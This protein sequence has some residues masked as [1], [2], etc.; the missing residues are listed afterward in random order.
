MGYLDGLDET[1]SVA[2]TR[3]LDGLDEDTPIDARNDRP[4][5]DGQI[6]NALDANTLLR[7]IQGAPKPTVEPVSKD[8]NRFRALSPEAVPEMVDP[9]T[10]EIDT[11]PPGLYQGNEQ[12]FA[13]LSGA[14]R[15][16]IQSF[17]TE[18]S[19]GAPKYMPGYKEERP[20]GWEK[21]PVGIGGAAGFIYGGPVA[22]FKGVTKGIVKKLP[23]L[24]LLGHEGGI[25]RFLKTAAK[26]VPA[27]SAAS[28]V[29]SAV[30]A[31]QAETP[32]QAWGILKDAA[33]G[34]ALMGGTFAGARSA[35]WRESKDRLKRMAYGMLAMRTIRGDPT[36]W[37]GI[38]EE[39]THGIIDGFFLL[40]G[41]PD[42]F[43]RLEKDARAKIKE[44]GIDEKELTEDVEKSIETGETFNPYKKMSLKAVQ[45][46]ARIGVDLAKVELARRES[47]VGEK[48]EGDVPEFESID[49]EKTF[50]SKKGSVYDK[51]DGVWYSK[52]G[53]KVT[54]TYIIKAAEKGSKGVVKEGEEIVG[55]HGTGLELTDVQERTSFSPDAKVSTA[56]AKERGDLEGNEPRLYKGKIKFENPKT[57]K[58]ED[59]VGFDWY[60]KAKEEGHDGVIITDGGKPVEYVVIKPE[61]VK[62]FNLE[63]TKETEEKAE[64][65]KVTAT[66][67]SSTRTAARLR[68]K[69]QTEQGIETE[70]VE[71]DGRFFLEPVKTEPELPA[72]TLTELRRRIASR[73]KEVLSGKGSEEELVELEVEME[74]LVSTRG[75]EDFK[76][77]SAYDEF[78]DLNDTVLDM[79][80]Q[81]K[82]EE[83]MPD[84]SIKVKGKEEETDYEKI[85]EKEGMPEE[86][87]FE[88][89]YKGTTFDFVGAQQFY[90]ILVGKL[91]KLTE[92]KGSPKEITKIKG[93]IRLVRLGLDRIHPAIYP[94][95]VIN[96]MYNITDNLGIQEVLDI[97]G[98]TGRIGKIKN[99]GFK[100]KIIANELEASWKGQSTEQIQKDFGVDSTIIGDARK[101]DIP[102]DSIE[103]IFTSPTYGNR[104]GLTGKNTYTD[105]VGKELDKGNTGGII[106]GPEYEGIHKDAY[107][108]SFRVLKPGGVF[109]LNMKDWPTS[110]IK[111]KKGSI[112]NVEDCIV[113]ATDWHISALEE[114]GFNTIR[115]YRVEEGRTVSSEH[116]LARKSTVGYEDIVIVQKPGGNYISKEILDKIDQEPL[117]EK[118]G[119][120]QKYNYY[121]EGEIT[122]DFLGLQQIWEGVKGRGDR[123]GQKELTRRAIKKREGKIQL[124]TDVDLSDI[125]QMARAKGLTDRESKQLITSKL[126]WKRSIKDLTREEADIIK[127]KLAQREAREVMEN[128][129]KILDN[130][131][132]KDS[133]KKVLKR[134]TRTYD[135]D[136]NEL[137]DYLS[138]WTNESG[139]F[140]NHDV[141]RVIATIRAVNELRPEKGRV[142]WSLLAPAKRLFGEE[143]MSHM[144]RAEIGRLED[145]TPYE[146]RIGEMFSGLDIKSNE[147]IS[148]F[149]EGKLKES[150]LSPQELKTA[151]KLRELYNEL[152]EVFD[153][154]GFIENYSPHLKKGMSE[155]EMIDW[156][157]SRKGLTELDFW[158][159]HTRKGE[160]DVKERDAK[161]MASS[162]VK[163]GLTKKHYGKAL[164][165]IKPILEGMSKERQDL[166]NK[167]LDTVVRRRPTGDE[168][169]MERLVKKLMK[170]LGMKVDES[171]R[172]YKQIVGTF[173]DMNYSAF[174][175]MRP[176]LALRNLTQQSLI[177]NEYGYGAYLEGRFGKYKKE[178][179]NAMENSDVYK[180]RKK[181][182]M[183]LEESVD[184]LKGIPKATRQKM[185][186]FYRMADLDNVETAF[187][188]GYL[189]AKKDH[190]GLAESYAIRAGEKAIHNTQ[191]GYGMD[192]PYLF[193]TPTGKFIGQY[194]SWPIWYAD[195]ISRI[196]KER[197]GAKAARTAVQAMIVG[198]LV[199]EYGI[200][201]TRTVLLG[202]F[203]DALG[204]GAQSVINFAHLG[205]TL[206]TFDAKKI[207]YAGTDTVEQLVLGLM[208][209]YLGAKDLSRALEGDIGGALIY[210]RKGKSRKGKGLGALSGGLGSLGKL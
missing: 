8:V 48:K 139:E 10:R 121:K 123:S 107:K 132:V 176:K 174:M 35:Y 67:S 80:R 168:I 73:A 55:Y 43:S 177:M 56:Y 119:Q 188:T 202:V 75:L 179:K 7:N 170:S 155:K 86:L 142:I 106:W 114:A 9:T 166:A 17:L 171:S 189:K 196:V 61:S 27:L 140:T 74:R 136:D 100:G 41:M 151:G 90:E 105:F 153:I 163:A 156:A 187:S 210:Q 14:A 40:H 95:R 186:W 126:G 28:T 183:V 162:Y 47:E 181:Q 112:V 53:K 68:Q 20:Y 173:L 103:S 69:K 54:N 205:K 60:E 133:T 208:P 25:A 38:E 127:L 12:D 144:R 169:V 66:E 88:R 199:K 78:M 19:F 175:G 89:E 52:G 203:P 65:K 6:F 32:E 1:K 72:E 71:S 204:F 33:I 197:N 46:N 194:M 198:L 59:K 37:H 178:V 209:G 29:S 50:T 164:E 138:T 154:K 134:A 76:S 26:E 122:L 129:Q 5:G 58:N 96:K 83:P 117:K 190:P 145:M 148:D 120:R 13:S 131:N 45:E 81:V 97:F 180:L 11:R 42:V 124:A 111:P 201:Y 118:R 137:G 200:D 101:L 85:L 34:G 84:R 22:V 146:K 207:A 16:S 70:I 57:I 143:F 191:W 185:M 99:Y 51:R 135:V 98:G 39:L 192:L 157:F 147:A 172:Y 44:E 77:E 3:Y 15:K 158:A 128:E 102:S 18:A 36:Q 113:K 167:W 116:A 149:F 141:N 87:D 91:N 161:R 82:R 160:L 193:K 63:T 2:G 30:D 130:P 23:T 182:Y 62:E 49:V 115:N 184:S 104:M 159:E 92:E 152:W 93:K 4:H 125:N 108:E 79:I 206:G 21:L 165:S 31:H 64:E 94:W 150:D 195:H 109:I 24:E 110:R